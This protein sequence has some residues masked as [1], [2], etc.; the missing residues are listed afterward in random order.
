[1]ELGNP[2]ALYFLGLVVLTAVLYALE[3]TSSRRAIERFA[4][5]GV[6]GKILRGYSRRRKI[7]KRCL[8]VF[9]LLSLILAWAMPR[10][11]RGTR[12]MKREGV[13]VAVALDMSTSMLAEDVRPN[14][15]DVAKQA[16]INLILR[17]PND[18]FALVGFA[19][20]GFIHCPLTLD[21]DALAMFVDFMNPGV[22]SEQGTNIGAAITESLKALES[23][24]GR[25]KAI[26]LV[27]DGEDHGGGVDAALERAE[28]E[29][30]RIYA[31]GVGTAGGEP[32]PIRDG[33]GNVRAYKRDERDEVI[34]T[35]LDQ[36]MLDR[37]S[38]TTGGESYRLD[39]GERE[40]S[41]LAKAIEGLEKGLF[42]ERTF[43]DYIELFPVPLLLCFLLLVT[44]AFIGDRVKHV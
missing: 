43:E 24:S 9:A 25:G 30:V 40:L 44:E 32:I 27:T 39:A 5:S 33:R 4:G 14:R 1:L 26:V 18:R 11:G 29:G 34:V 15:M 16:L 42:E 22:V 13:D 28:A 31:V 19:G 6:V 17:L 10:A 7:I 38:G 8:V 12:V 41:K 20:T 37:L 35:R 23:S 3:L 36:G 21:K 2:I